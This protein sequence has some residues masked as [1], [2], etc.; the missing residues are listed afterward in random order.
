MR[1]TRVVEAGGIIE[2]G[3]ATVA[4]DMDGTMTNCGGR[5]AGAGRRMVETD[6]K[7]RVHVKDSKKMRLLL[8]VTYFV[9]VFTFLVRATVITGTGYFAHKNSLRMPDYAQNKER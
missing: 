7:G 6:G 2:G 1:L 8:C 9:S 3:L 5:G 4:G